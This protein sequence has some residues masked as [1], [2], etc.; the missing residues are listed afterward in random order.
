[1]A[2]NYLSEMLKLPVIDSDGEKVGIVNDM[3]IATG[4]VFPHVTSLAFQGPGNTPF[5]ISWR[6][7]VDHMD[8]S[9]VYLNCPATDIRFSYLQPDEVLVARDIL[10]KQIVDTQGIKVVRVN[11]IKFSTTDDGQLRLLGAEVGARGLLRAL[12]PGLERVVVRMSKAL[13]KPLEEDIIAWSYMDLLDRNT[14]QL[15]LSVSHKTLAELHP[16]DVADII[17]QL[18][19]RLRSQVFA[20]LDTTQAAEAISEIEDDELMTEMLE[21]MSDRD[22]A[23]MLAAMDPDDA[24]DLVEELDYEKAEKLLRLMGVQEEKAIRILLGYAE[25]TAGR[26]MTSD[27]VALPGTATVSDAIAAIAELDEDFQAVYYVYTTD[28]DGAL[29]GVLSLRRLIVAD[30]DKPLKDLA[31]KDVVFVSPELDQEDVA[32]EMTKYNLVAIPVCDDHQRILGIVTFD[33][34]ME[35]MAEEH[36]EDLKI[37]GMGNAENAGGEKTSALA[38]F[39]ERQYW[40]VIWV[41]CSSIIALVVGALGGQVESFIYPMCT[42]PVALLTASRTVT[43]V[44]NFFLEYDEPDDEPKPY[45]AFWVKNVGLGILFALIILICGQM[46]SLAGFADT[47]S[48]TLALFKQCF[49]LTAV[50]TLVSFMTSVIYLKVLFW[51]DEHD[52]DTSGAAL[53]FIGI[54]VAAVLYTV[55]A[56]WIVLA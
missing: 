37:A 52:L 1:M 29:T 34:A 25:N 27:F 26:I 4:E 44:K 46:V 10:N 49:N 42:M 56:I 51:R 18:D 5:M 9:G 36:E 55:G 23:S 33:D 43:Y 8:E 14:T 20:Q 47:A 45:L 38:W 11:D 41:I 3:G 50:V 40:V 17:E 28:S 32:E 54:L 48:A 21:G 53:T 7:Y 31:Y 12:S 30:P 35:V 15:Q 39:G 24:A 19:P 6:K 16:A 22:A 2:L 13:G